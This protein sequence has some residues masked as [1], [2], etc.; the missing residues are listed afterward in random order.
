[1][2]EEVFDNISY[3]YQRY[4]DERKL[5]IEGEAQVSARF[6]NGML[7]LSGG[8]LLL[9]MTFIKEVIEGVPC[10]IWSII[11]A[12][13]MFAI[14]ITMIL[15]S[16]VSSQKAFRRQRDILDKDISENQ[17]DGSNLANTATKWLNNISIVTFII[18]VMFFAVFVVNNMEL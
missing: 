4:L 6:D 3:R 2:K 12:W 9:S 11:I 16:L 14:T 1:M 13:L 10:S 18:G 17:D 5:L 15:V 7:T 8:S